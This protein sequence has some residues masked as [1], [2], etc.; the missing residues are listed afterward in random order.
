MKFL[1]IVFSLGLLRVTAFG[2]PLILES[3]RD[4]LIMTSE[5]VTLVAE[6]RQSQ[7]HGHFSFAGARKPETTYARIEFPIITGKK[8]RPQVPQLKVQ[9][10][11]RALLP[12]KWEDGKAFGLPNGCGLQWFSAEIPTNELRGHIN[13]SISYIQPHLRKN[14]AAYLPIQPPKSRAS[15]VFQGAPGYQVEP[16]TPGWAKAAANQIE[17][18]PQDRNFLQV[19]VHP[20]KQQNNKRAKSEANS[21]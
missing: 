5:H 4:P 8:I 2:N 9:G 21:K 1:F 18:I 13:V 10:K 16:E 17:Y 20:I 6:K 15:V 12:W 7:V 3:A 14:I 19:R 11:L